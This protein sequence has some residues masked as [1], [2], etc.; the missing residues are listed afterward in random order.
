[1]IH[2]GR[3]VESGV[4]ACL[5]CRRL[6]DVMEWAEPCV[7]VIARPSGHQAFRCRCGRAVFLPMNAPDLELFRAIG[8]LCSQC[9]AHGVEQPA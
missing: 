3:L 2:E 9:R 4:F 7:P 8:I 1:M 6:L 5:H